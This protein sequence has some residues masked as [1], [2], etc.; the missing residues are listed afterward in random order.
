VH[1]P[2]IPRGGIQGRLHKHDPPTNNTGYY[3]WGEWGAGSISLPSSTSLWI[4]AQQGHREAVAHQGHP[5]HRSW[6]LC[7][8]VAWTVTARPVTHS[9][10]HIHSAKSAY[11][12]QCYDVQNLEADHHN[13]F[14]Q[15]PIR[16]ISTIHMHIDTQ[17]GPGSIWCHNRSKHSSSNHTAE[18]S[19]PDPLR[20]RQDVIEISHPPYCCTDHS[21]FVL[22]S[23]HD[24]ENIGGTTT[25]AACTYGS[26]VHL[27]WS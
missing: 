11:D 7:A 19:G 22:R 10:R 26:P 18:T 24:I 14:T 16:A 23:T 3:H 12:I 21:T 17:L 20:M 8:V 25:G 2:A 5:P 4:A 13:I 9:N 1:A 15:P 6:A 27:T